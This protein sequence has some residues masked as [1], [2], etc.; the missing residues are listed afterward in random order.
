M[1]YMYMNMEELIPYFEKFDK[2]YWKGS[3]QTMFKQLDHMREHGI[4]VAQAS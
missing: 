2:I 1:L 3:E 4:K